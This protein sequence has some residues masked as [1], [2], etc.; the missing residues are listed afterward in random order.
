MITSI[1]TYLSTLPMWLQIVSF[2]AMLLIPFGFAIALIYKVFKAD[3]IK[4]GP[5]EIDMSEDKKE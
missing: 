2:I 5:V 4:A 3:K 1:T